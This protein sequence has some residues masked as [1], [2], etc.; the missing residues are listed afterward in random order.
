MVSV[1]DTE[2]SLHIR[3]P[4]T[5]LKLGGGGGYSGQLKLKV[6]KFANFH[7]KVGVGWVYFG[8]IKPEVPTSLTF[9]ILGGGGYHGLNISER[10]NVGFLN[11]NFNFQL[12]TT[13]NL[14]HTTYVET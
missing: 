4:Y 2:I 7:W 14:S 6:P 9:F 12:A 3:F 5:S 1:V 11:A 10:N 13:D 8:P